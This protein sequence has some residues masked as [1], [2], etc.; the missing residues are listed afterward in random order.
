MKKILRFCQKAII[1]KDGKIL[2]VK[3]SEVDPS[4]FLWEFPGGGINWGEDLEAGFRREL[5]EELGPDIDIEIG[6]PVHVSSWVHPYK[7]DLAYAVWSFF[8]CHY[9][10]GKIQ[11][12]E[13]HLEYQWVDPT[14][15]EDYPMLEMVKRAIEK[16]NKV[17]KEVNCP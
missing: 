1:E 9:K 3:T 7:R 11:L 8:I 5:F 14:K 12:S 2:L 13:E 17:K 10:K 4:P 6:N 16:Y 15:L